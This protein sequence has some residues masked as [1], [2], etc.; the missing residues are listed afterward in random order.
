MHLMNTKSTPLS[1]VTV[2][3][4]F[5]RLQTLPRQGDYPQSGHRS[6]VPCFS[7]RWP[8]RLLLCVTPTAATYPED[9]PPAAA[10]A[11]WFRTAYYLKCLAPARV[12][13]CCDYRSC[14]IGKSDPHPTEFSQ[15]LTRR[16]SPKF[17]IDWLRNEGFIFRVGADGYP[18]IEEEHC[19]EVTHEGFC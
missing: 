7:D 5:S 1:T 10:F 11:R 12:K 16:K 13:R 19:L 18:K 17:M 15:P 4:Q 6:E 14:R 3:F 2:T 9:S 8:L